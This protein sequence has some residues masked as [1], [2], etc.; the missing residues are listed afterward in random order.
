M[1][2]C[3]PSSQCRGSVDDADTASTESLQYLFARCCHGIKQVDADEGDLRLRPDSPYDEAGPRFSPVTPDDE[4]RRAAIKAN[5]RF[6]DVHAEAKVPAVVTPRDRSAGSSSE[7]SVD[8]SAEFAAEVRK[9]EEAGKGGTPKEENTF[10]NNSS[11]VAEDKVEKT[12]EQAAL[13]VEILR[14]EQRLLKWKLARKKRERMIPSLQRATE[15]GEDDPAILAYD[16]ADDEKE[17]NT[18]KMP[19][20]KEEMDEKDD[21]RSIGASTA[22]WSQADVVASAFPEKKAEEETADVDL[23]AAKQAVADHSATVEEAEPI[24][25][26]RKAKMASVRRAFGLQEPALEDEAVAS[27]AKIMEDLQGLNSSASGAGDGGDDA[28]APDAGVPAEAKETDCGEEPKANKAGEDDDAAAALE[29]AVGEDHSEAPSLERATSYIIES[30]VTNFSY[31]DSEPVNGDDADKPLSKADEDVDGT[32]EDAAEDAKEEDANEGDEGE[33]EASDS[34][35]AKE[36]AQPFPGK[37]KGLFKRAFGK[38][39]RRVSS[40]GDEA[41]VEA[42]EKAVADSMS[43]DEIVPAGEVE[44]DRGEVL[45]ASDESSTAEKVPVASE[46]SSG[47]AALNDGKAL[48]LGKPVQAK[49]PKKKSFLKRAFGK[50]KLSSKGDLEG[51]VNESSDDSASDDDDFACGVDLNVTLTG[52][53]EVLAPSQRKLLDC[54]LSPIPKS[55]SRRLLDVERNRSN[56]TVSMTTT[57]ESAGTVDHAAATPPSRSSVSGQSLPPTPPTPTKIGE[58]WDVSFLFGLSS[59]PSP[60][61]SIIG[62]TPVKVETPDAAAVSRQESGVNETFECELQGESAVDIRM[63]V[64]VEDEPR[65]P[66]K[67][68]RKLSFSAADNLGASPFQP[69][70]VDVATVYRDEKGGGGRASTTEDEVQLA[71]AKLRAFDIAKE[72][73]K[74]RKMSLKKKPFAKKGLADADANNVTH[75][76]AD[77]TG[78]VSMLCG[79]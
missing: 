55:P 65:P 61:E 68:N 18:E 58:S 20:A 38:K 8:F 53:V 59:P 62:A 14:Q 48:L 15:V 41:A 10:G 32:E 34:D 36:D 72:A 66:P 49:K 11:A 64:G 77:L 52:D 25:K 30:I 69:Q 28:K 6:C 37:K 54:P 24:V 47:D 27:A 74:G 35:D 73:R 2:G 67:V 26:D 45:N 4:Q 1:S 60:S 71:T 50:S 21:G 5:S 31:C 22:D 17:A 3:V 51:V 13:D 70:A 16:S 9:A 23:V 33:K 42:D 57:D 63:E 46:S 56:G 12:P 39:T 78:D 44:E 43:N 29:P 19:A 7:E 79:L 40:K 75:A 76:T